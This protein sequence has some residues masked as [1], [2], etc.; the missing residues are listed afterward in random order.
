METSSNSLVDSQSVHSSA[1][2]QIQHSMAVNR[3]AMGA[4]EAVSSAV[5]WTR[6]ARC[7]ALDAQNFI[8]T[9]AD[10][11]YIRTVFNLR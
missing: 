11:D 10:T 9:R 1:S 8:V 2:R 4:G 5:T 7:Y 3:A 6:G